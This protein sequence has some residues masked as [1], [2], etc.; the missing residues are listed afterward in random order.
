[1]TI[2]IPKPTCCDE[3][4]RWPV[5]VA[6]LDGKSEDT[7]ECGARWYFRIAPPDRGGGPYGYPEF[8]KKYFG[9]PEPSNCP[10]CGTALPKLRVKENPPPVTQVEHVNDGGYYCNTCGERCGWGCR[11]LPAI[12]RFEVES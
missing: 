11:C 2:P 3:I 5:I 9:A 10:F 7:N 1:M 4:Q 12:C 8:Q 6:G